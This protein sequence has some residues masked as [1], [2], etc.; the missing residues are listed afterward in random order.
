MEKSAGLAIVYDNMLLLVHSTGSPWWASYGIPKGWIEQNENAL[1]AAKRE[2][3]EEVGIN[4]PPELINGATQSLYYLKDNRAY[5]Q[6]IYYV[7]RIN[8]LLI[9]SII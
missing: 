9:S 1:A 4:V 2:T 7:A 3:F 5:K 6:I 8:D